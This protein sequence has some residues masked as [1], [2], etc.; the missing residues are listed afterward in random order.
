[1]STPAVEK[2]D[3]V[4]IREVWAENLEAEFAVIREIVDDYPYVAMEVGRKKSKREI[5]NTHH[6]QF[7]TWFVDHVRNQ[8]CY[9]II[10]NN[11]C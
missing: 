3:G 7:H 2:P 8:L 9:Y 4:E 11:I 6:K 1:M 5:E 10:I